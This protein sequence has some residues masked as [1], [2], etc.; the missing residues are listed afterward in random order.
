[1]HRQCLFW[2]HLPTEECVRL[3][4]EKRVCNVC[5]FESRWG[6][7]PGIWSVC[8]GTHRNWRLSKLEATREDQ[9]LRGA[10]PASSCG[11][12]SYSPDSHQKIPAQTWNSL[13]WNDKTLMG[14]PEKWK[15]LCK[16][17]DRFRVWQFSRHGKWQLRQSHLHSY[18][19]WTNQRKLGRW[20]TQLLMVC[21]RCAKNCPSQHLLCEEVILYFIIKQFSFSSFKQTF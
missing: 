21:W 8:A 10:S 2:N 19:P 6:Y 7:N 17:A 14:C 13:S 4:N 20:E 5:V 16:V 1:M 3:I 12:F 15:S 11:V 18:L 9:R